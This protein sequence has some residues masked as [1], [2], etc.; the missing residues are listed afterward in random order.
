MVFRIQP[1]RLVVISRSPIKIAF[2]NPPEVSARK[3]AS[4]VIRIETNC[5]TEI[6]D[7]FIE[8][9]FGVPDFRSLLEMPI[10]LRIG[11]EVPR[12]KSATALLKSPL[13]CQVSGLL[14]ESPRVLWIE[15]NRLVEI[16]DGLIEIAFGV[17]GACP[18]LESPRVFRIEA[19]RLAE[20]SD[21]LVE[22]VFGVRDFPALLI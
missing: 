2:V 17:P 7:G 12:L 13:A 8:I 10:V 16:S 1:N 9:A 22:I 15:S 21:S 4:R 19:N 14:I 5:L 20:V 3:K 6:R 18:H 11:V